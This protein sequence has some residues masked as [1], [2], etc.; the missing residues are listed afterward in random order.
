MTFICSKNRHVAVWGWIGRL[1][2]YMMNRCQ[3][4][5]EEL[6]EPGMGEICMM[7]NEKK[8]VRCWV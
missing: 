8:A 5:V 1:L 4:L 3:V 6:L 7:V 2:G